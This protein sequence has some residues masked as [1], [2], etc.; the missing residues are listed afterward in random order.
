M[1]KYPSNITYEQPS[2]GMSN[3]LPLASPQGGSNYQ[4]GWSQPGGTYA[5]RGNQN[6]RN[7]PLVGGFNPSQQGGYTIPDENQFP[8]GGYAQYPNHM[9]TNPHQGMYPYVNNTYP[10]MPYDGSRMNVNQHPFNQLTQSQFAPT[11]LPF[12]ATLEFPKLSKLTNNPIQHYFTWPSVPVKIPTDIQKF[13]GRTGEDPANHITTYHL[14]CVSNYFLDDSVKL[15]LFPKTL[16]R[17]IAKWFIELS[18]SSSFDFQSLAIVFLTHF[19]LP[20]WYETSTKLLT[21][22]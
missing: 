9:S 3:S 14:W 6:V 16:T 15:C 18:T 19:Q 13:D 11:K 10:R 7:I 22:L 20:I 21:L 5:P 1:G 2:V 12:M 8:M 17:N 4:T